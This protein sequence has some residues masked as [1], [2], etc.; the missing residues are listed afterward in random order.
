M[1][2]SVLGTST[3]STYVHCHVTWKPFHLL[4][5]PKALRRDLEVSKPIIGISDL[6]VR[7][8]KLGGARLLVSSDT[9]KEMQELESRPRPGRLQSH[10]LEEG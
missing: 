2:P 1:L 5:C 10:G 8:R 4:S 6:L 7:D 9:L 3:D